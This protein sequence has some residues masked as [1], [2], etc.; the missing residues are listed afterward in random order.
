MKTSKVLG[1]VSLTVM[2]LGCE[3]ADPEKTAE[4]NQET[5]PSNDCSVLAASE[6]ALNTACMAIHGASVNES[7]QC[8]DADQFV[9]C[10]ESQACGGA[11]AH[12]RDMLGTLWQFSDTCTPS[13]WNTEPFDYVTRVCENKA[14]LADDCSSLSEADCVAA[15][16]NC[17]PIHGS[18]YNESEYC[19]E[20]NQ[21]VA[22]VEAGQCGEIITKAHDPSGRLWFFS[23]SC[24]PPGWEIDPPSLWSGCDEGVPPDSCSHLSESDCLAASDKCVPIDGFHINGL[25]QCIG[26]FATCVEPKVCGDAMT[27][28]RDPTGTLWIFPSTCT[29]VGWSCPGFVYCSE[30]ICGF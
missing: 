3:N 16:E 5:V 24:T 20:P 9:A 25:G 1:I 12:A 8:V 27:G 28:R 10:V 4:S 11:I 15:G 23:D 29:P 18:P 21:F 6:C 30:K 2:A 14:E 17:M 19:A 7:E 22:C 26:E 13:G